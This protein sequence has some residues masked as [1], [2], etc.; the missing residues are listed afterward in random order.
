MKIRHLIFATIVVS[1]SLWA[2]PFEDGFEAYKRKD[3]T[4]ALKLFR[5]SAAQGEPSAQYRVGLMYFKGEGVVQDYTEAVKW[6]RLAAEQGHVHAQQNLGN[7]F[8]LGIGVLQDF[9]EG[10]KW[11][12]LAAA[13]GFALAQINLATMYVNAEGVE[14]DLVRAHSWL[15]LA[16]VTDSANATFYRDIISQLMTQQQMAEAQKLAQ[17]CQARNFKGCN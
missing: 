15:S 4:E 16:A 5:L 1:S 14:R 8:S 3:Y 9:A 13:Q 17:D 10:L 11:Y 2:G 7:M 12:R 6:Y